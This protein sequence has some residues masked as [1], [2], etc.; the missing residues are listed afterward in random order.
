VVTELDGGGT[1]LVET[2]LATYTLATL[3]FVET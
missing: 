2:A 1:D 3:A